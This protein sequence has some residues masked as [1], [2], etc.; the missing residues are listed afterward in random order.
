M[1]AEVKA[2]FGARMWLVEVMGKRH[3]YVAGDR[4]DSFLPPQVVGLNER[5]ALVSGDWEKIPEKRKRDIIE[6]LRAILIRQ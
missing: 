6:S 5:Y 3:S 2:E 4:D 1:A